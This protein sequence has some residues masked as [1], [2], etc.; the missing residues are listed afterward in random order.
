MKGIIDVGGGNRGIYG[1][2][3]L[4]YCLDNGIKFDYFIGVSA[5]SANGASFLAGQRGRNYHF[6]QEFSFRREYMS[7]RNF[8]RRGSYINLDYIY[9]TLSNDGGAYPIDYETFI[10]NP[11]RMTVVATDA[12]SGKPV[13]F[14]KS[15]VQKD[16]YEIFKASSCVPAVNRP[17]IFRDKAYFDGGISD[18][19]PLRK[20]LDEG[21]DR[22][23]LI[24]TRPKRFFRRARIDKRIARLLRQRY[25]KTA[26][27]MIK[28]SAL[29]NAQLRTALRLEAE[30]KL[31]IVAPDD[32]SGLKTLTKNH[33]RLESL[34]QKGYTDAKAIKAYLSC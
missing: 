25:P 1:A 24:L 10:N 19:I 12:E 14:D 13:Y 6:Y 22:L 7:L 8:V 32:I 34:Y 26:E 4:D 11:A 31:L 29:Y 28:R 30:G 3:V 17:Y 15:D 20:A 27:S 23:V 9:G 5:G 21:C 33:E 18:P 2:G 16:H